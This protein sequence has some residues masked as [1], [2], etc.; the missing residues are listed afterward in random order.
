MSTERL[1]REI[2]SMLAPV[3]DHL[4]AL[5]DRIIA[6]E[7]KLSL[8]ECQAHTNENPI[9]NALAEEGDLDLSGSDS[10]TPSSTPPQS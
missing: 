4:K 10:D 8:Q 9:F 2:R 3:Y 1:F 5:E 7:Q 6:I